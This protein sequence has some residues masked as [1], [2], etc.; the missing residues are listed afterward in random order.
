MI[1][2]V[3]G[4]SRIEQGQEAEQRAAE[5]L[6]RQG[7]KP[8]A[9]NYRCRSG[10]I[11]LIM[12]SHDSLVFVEVRFRR[13]TGFGGAAASVD[14]RKQQ[15][16]LATA[17]YYLQKNQAFNQPCRFDVVAVV[18]GSDGTLSFDWIKN[19]FELD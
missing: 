3:N 1:P 10:E 4:K 5:Y 16:L 11:D 12:Q 19:A 9:R 13:H 6:C 8:L 17:Q 15:R 7:L 14:R 2:R 18:P